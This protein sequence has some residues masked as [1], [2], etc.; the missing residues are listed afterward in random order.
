M[1]YQV[2]KKQLFFSQIYQYVYKLYTVERE[3]NDRLLRNSTIC[4]EHN[5]GSEFKDKPLNVLT[6][7][8]TGALAT[9]SLGT[10]LGTNNFSN[11]KVNTFLGVIRSLD[12]RGRL[13]TA[14]CLET[15]PYNQGSRLTA[16]EL[17]SEGIPHCLVTD[18]M[19][20]S[21]MRKYKIHAVLVGKFC[22]T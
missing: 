4:V 21:V 9:C 5:V 22:C 13:G 14:F 11:H 17:W 12:Q 1:S 19:A 10:A 3:E 16:Y 20:A 2:F 6:I 15:R 7:C 18:S 8:N